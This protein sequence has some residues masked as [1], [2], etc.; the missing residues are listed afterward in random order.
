MFG[1]YKTA[2]TIVN[3]TVC[4]TL[5]SKSLITWPLFLVGSTVREIERLHRRRF[6]LHQVET[7]SEQIPA[8]R[9][10]EWSCLFPIGFIFFLG[11][12]LGE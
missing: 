2:R 11:A 3:S 5:V 1:K 7:S 10:L 12:K 8:W 4:H 6:K 9:V